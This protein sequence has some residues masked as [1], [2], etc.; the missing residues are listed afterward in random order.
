MQCPTLARVEPNA[1][2][3]CLVTREPVASPL[4][5]TYA[6][7]PPNRTASLERRR[8]NAAKLSERIAG[9][10]IDA[11]L[12]YD[13][14]DEAARNSAPRPFPF[15]PKVDALEYAFEELS[16]GE[17]PR[18]VYR[19][20]AD[21]D[22]ATLRGWI[23]RL[24]ARNARAVFVGAPS[25][26]SNTALKLPR[27]FQVCRSYRPELAF[28]GVLIA[29]RHQKPGDEDARV[30]AKRQQGCSFFVSQTVWSTAATTALLRD[31]QIRAALA[32]EAP[33]SILVTLSPCGS[34][35][36]LAFQEWLGVAVPDS[37]KRELLSARDMLERSVELAADVFAEVHSVAA[38]LGM[39]V[40]C[41]VESV[42]SRASEIDASLELLKRITAIAPAS[43][44]ATSP[45]PV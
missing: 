26:G 5:L 23:E 34:E 1:A 33:P 19:A 44:M 25:R 38:R 37:L 39:T 9:L 41:N 12:V 36:T 7:T 42:S 6:I 3:F 22:E 31:L 43:R 27:A 15:V 16:L 29:E 28:G 35:Q 20:I 40:G 4:T 32:L 45:A 13:L 17:L 30:W 21:Q 11:L 2:S 14:Q 18:V 24:A 10:P 8:A